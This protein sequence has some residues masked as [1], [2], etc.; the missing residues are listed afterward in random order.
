MRIVV[1]GPEGSGKGT[2]VALL[3]KRFGWP[4]V[5]TG[6]LLR[7]AM[8]RRTP[9]GRA[10]ARRMNRGTYLPTT[11]VNRLLLQWLRNPRRRRAFLLDGYPRK[12][13]QL[14]TLDRVTAI[15]AAIIFDLPD[16]EAVTRLA[17]RRVSGCGRVYHLRF[18]PPPASGRCGTCHDRLR[19]R[20]DDRPAQ[21]RGRLR[22]YHRF[23]DPVIRAYDRRKIGLHIDA[24]PGISAIARRL[25]SALARWP[26]ATS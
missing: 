26:R 20:E 9:L 23:A 22:A 10:I 14:H 7:A 11:L 25:R 8:H 13:D 19:Q 16:R 21:V 1:I 3:A 18:N 17:G 12:L 15:D 2:Q 5:S 4:S 6:D 24:R